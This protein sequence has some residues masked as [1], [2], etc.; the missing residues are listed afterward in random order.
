MP[1]PQRILFVELLGGIGDTLIALPAIQALAATYPQAHLAVLTFAPGAELLKHHPSIHQVI[2]VHQG[3]ARASVNAIL[4]EPFDLIVSD[5]SYEEIDQLIEQALG[6]SITN[7]W[8]SPP[9]NQRVSDRF[10]ALLRNDGIIDAGPYPPPRL[11]LTA[12]EQQAARDRLGPAFRPL[13]GLCP[14]AGTQTKR[15]PPEHFVALG[16]SLRAQYGASVVVPV[17]D[18]PDLAAAIAAGIGSSAQVWPRG[19]LRQ[20]AAMLQQVDAVVAADTGPARIAAAL[21]TPTV[22]LFGPAWAG[23]YGQPPPHINLQGYPDCPHRRPHNFTEQDCWYGDCPLDWPTCTVEITP[24]AVLEALAPHL[25]PLKSPRHVQFYNVTKETTPRPSPSPPIPAWDRAAI[26]RLLVMRLDNIGDVIMT[27]PSLRALRQNLPDAHIT[28]LASPAGAKTA[29]LLPWVNEV[30]P[31]R[32]LW[33]DLGKLPFD[34]EREWAL[35]E[36]LRAGQ[37]DAAVILTS[38]SQSP[39]PA[40]LVCEL[41]GIPRRLGESKETDWGTLTHAVAP[42]PDTWHQVE[43]NLRLVEAVGWAVTERHLELA[44]PTLDLP[45]PPDYI[46]L[47][48]WTTCQSRNY[49]AQRFAQAARQLAEKTGYPVV[50]SGVARDRHQAGPLLKHLGTHAIDLIGQTRLEQL[51][52]IIA[53]ARLMLSNNTSTMHIAD[54]TG[55][56]SVITFAGTEL[57]E[58]WRPRRAPVALLRRPTVCSPCYRF[59]CLYALECL[60]LEPESLVAA[61]LQ[62]LN[63]SRVTPQHLDTDPVG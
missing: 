21:G 55:T 54:A 37:F 44:V 30:I 18:E 4:S 17:G 32:T 1:T 46:V 3:Q 59:E 29:P 5:T 35:V 38:F 47:Y 14:E 49:D 48:P 27:S 13:V 61:G 56:P 11:Y 26:R 58:Q 23:R 12:A 33:Q 19:D 40:A 22:T 31:W 63:G 50:V 36:A 20:L 57:E 2:P 25:D 60:D 51:V 62:L 24:E 15:W 41:A 7:L 52:T 39:H 43:R 45:L 9:A 34:P 53:R 28:L 6:Q 8:R 10:L 16:R 42:A